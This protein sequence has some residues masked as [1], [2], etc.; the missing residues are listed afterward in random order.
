MSRPGDIVM[1]FGVVG[2]PPWG[3]IA[4]WAAATAYTVGPPASAV[5][6]AGAVYVCVTPHV[7]GTTFD[8]SKWVAVG[9]AGGASGGGIDGG[10][11]SD[12]GSGG[13]ID[14]GTP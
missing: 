14:G 7:S 8:P 4:P 13:G 10:S 2:P 6:Y 5:S 1:R 11:P 12:T 3:P 9:G